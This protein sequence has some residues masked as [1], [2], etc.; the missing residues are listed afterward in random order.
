MPVT[1]GTSYASDDRDFVEFPIEFVGDLGGDDDAVRAV[2]VHHIVSL[3]V[4]KTLTAD[5][6][7]VGVVAG[8]GSGGEG[9]GVAP[10]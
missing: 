1:T 7:W 4:G 10:Y 3:A 2:V 9:V 8:G 5:G 6:F